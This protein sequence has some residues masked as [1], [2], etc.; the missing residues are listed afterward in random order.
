MKKTSQWRE[1]DQTSPPACANV[2][3][4]SG[5]FIFHV[6]SFSRYANVSNQNQQLFNGTILLQIDNTA[7]SSN[8]TTEYTEE[9]MVEEFEE[10]ELSGASKRVE[11]DEDTDIFYLDDYPE[12]IMSFQ[13]NTNATFIPRCA[14][15]QI[16][17]IKL[18][19]IQKYG[20][21]CTGT[22]NTLSKRQ[23]N[24]NQT[25]D[26]KES[27]ESTVE[28]DSSSTTQPQ[29]DFS[30]L[31]MEADTTTSGDT[32]LDSVIP[33]CI[34]MASMTAVTYM[35]ILSILCTGAITHWP[36]LQM[37]SL[38]FSALTFTVTFVL[39]TI[40]LEEQTQAGYYSGSVLFDFMD[41]NLAISV[42]FLLS[43]I[44]TRFAEVQI[45]LRLFR[46]PVE[47][48]VIIWIGSILN[49]TY[50]VIWGMFIYFSTRANSYIDGQTDTSSSTDTSYYYSLTDSQEAVAVFAYLFKIS[51]SILYCC[52]VCAYCIIM[53]NIAFRKELLIIALFSLVSIFLPIMLF[54][55]DIANNNVNVDGSWVDFVDLVALLGSTVVLHEWLTRIEQ[56]ER[57]QQEN[58]VL[59]KQLY[60]ET[61]STGERKMFRK[62][63]GGGVDGAEFYLGNVAAATS[64]T[65]TTTRSVATKLSSAS[66]AQFFKEQHQH[67]M[68]EKMIQQQQKPQK[69]VKWKKSD[70]L[71]SK[72]TRRWRCSSS[73]RGFPASRGQGSPELPSSLTSSAAGRKKSESSSTTTLAHESIGSPMS[74]LYRTEDP[75]E[76]RLESSNSASTPTHVMSQGSTSGPSPLA[77][78]VDASDTGLKNVALRET[79]Q[80][81]NALQ[82]HGPQP[83]RWLWLPKW[84]SDF[85]SSSPAPLLP[86]HSLSPQTEETGT[87]SSGM[88]SGG[89]LS[90]VT[91][92]TDSMPWWTHL[93]FWQH[94]MQRPDTSSSNQTTYS[95]CDPP[96]AAAPVPQ[97][98]LS[99]SQAQTLAQVQRQHMYSPM[100][101]SSPESLAY[102]DA[103]LSLPALSG[104]PSPGPNPRPS[105]RSS[106]GPQLSLHYGPSPPSNHVSIVINQAGAGRFGHTSSP[107]GGGSTQ[108]ASLPSAKDPEESAQKEQVSRYYYP[109]KHGKNVSKKN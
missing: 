10:L 4:D 68:A 25:P 76:D 5:V 107:N 19:S 15:G 30:F 22:S 13:T 102:R 16:T 78:R 20:R 106:P 69:Q 66:L 17:A 80:E 103:V 53:R 105:S 70:G 89:R 71:I 75:D 44:I 37:I 50:G 32:F 77:I 100:M 33:T 11:T 58:S 57:K 101:T 41:N 3:L 39:V 62:T 47:S 46:R 56:L 49:I 73:R 108:R 98:Q 104:G 21:N 18:E 86:L 45:L 79:P 91:P 31:A 109:R 8:D 36:L 28:T 6:D 40:H 61:D 65:A 29:F 94:P 42:L 92:T 96:P 82:Q 48:R 84:M 74:T 60:L 72:K 52:C 34:I 9:D 85:S 90:S 51:M 64:T 14:A 55:L 54:F 35:I 23:N 93:F 99:E 83:R 67:Q 88:Y 95:E 97:R 43:T 1:V 81:N 26:I 38:G 63:F 2:S 12:P 7:S 87:F 27:L 59:G 24:G